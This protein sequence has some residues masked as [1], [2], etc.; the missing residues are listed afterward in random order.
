M[1]VEM[2]LE[3]TTKR[4]VEFNVVVCRAGQASKRRSGAASEQFRGVPFIAEQSVVEFY[5]ARYGR[6][7][8]GQFVRALDMSEFSDDYPNGLCMYGGVPDWDV[9]SET[10]TRVADYVSGFRDAM[11]GGNGK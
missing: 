2:M 4:G 1:G 6:T 3:V 7:D 9:D 11:T 10:M 5:D 8:L